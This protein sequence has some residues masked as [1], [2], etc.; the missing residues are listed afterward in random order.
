MTDRN[1]EMTQIYTSFGGSKLLQHAD[2]LDSIQNKQKFKPVMV[3]LCP[4]EVCDSDCPFCS[5]AGR[6]I[7]SF[8]PFSDIKTV[9]ED[10][11]TLGAKSLEITGGG[12]PMLYRDRNCGAD[13]NDIVECAYNLGYKTGIIT[14]SHNLKRLKPEVHDMVHW[15]RVSLIQL[16]EG[17][18]PEDYD[19]NG[20]PVDRIAFSYIT[21]DTGGVM[22][23][24]SRT[25]KAYPGTT[26]E[27]I[28]RVA[29]L[30]EL[31]PLIKFV[32]IYGNCLIKGG[33]PHYKSQYQDIVNE[34]DKFDKF[35]IKEIGMDD[36]PFDDACYI[37]MLRPYIAP[38]PIGGNYQVYTCNS[39]VLNKRTYDLDYSLC[40]VHNI[41]PTWNEMNKRYQEKG[42]PY[43]VKGNKGRG[44]LDTCKYCYY[45]FSNRL[46]HGVAQKQEDGVF[47]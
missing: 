1:L 7:K 32:R 12:N 6:P 18:N 28:R 14:N 22:D 40:N 4:T 15:L 13:I 41:I 46:L 19:F 35:F 42:Y 38:D 29:K 11:R 33:H 43:E 8:M 39:F 21:Y 24:L 27:S 36:N 2:V 20:F 17:K 26:V 16:D 34:V 37:G 23:P 10:F 44:W 5:V 3:E 30:V 9:L 31:H 47:I 45:Q 25:K